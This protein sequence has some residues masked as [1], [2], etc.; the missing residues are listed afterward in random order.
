MLGIEE[1]HELTMLAMIVK[2]LHV[3][4]EILN[5]VQN[6]HSNGFET[7]AVMLNL[8]Q[9]LRQNSKKIS[10]SVFASE[11]FMIY[12]NQYVISQNLR[13]GHGNSKKSKVCCKD[14]GRKSVQEHS[15]R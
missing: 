12:C 6:D 3:R 4:I 5:Q 13:R 14:Q 10:Y 11:F 7:I 9:H 1:F 8:F 2:K 15:S